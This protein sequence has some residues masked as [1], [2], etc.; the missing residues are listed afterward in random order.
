MNL[1]P[2]K[3]AT[4]SPGIASNFFA[5][6]PPHLNSS[7]NLYACYGAYFFEILLIS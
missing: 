4:P 2:K 7:H 6:A 5:L 1:L 3:P